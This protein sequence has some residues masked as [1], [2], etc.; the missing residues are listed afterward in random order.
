MTTFILAFTTGEK[1]KINEEEAKAIAKTNDNQSITLKRLGMVI[2]KRMVQVYPEALSDTLADRRK[3][4]TGVLYDGTRVRRHFGRWIK[5]DGFV[6]DDDSSYQ[7]VRID[8]AYYPEVGRDCVPTE[9]EWEEIKL[10]PATERR[11]FIAKLSGG[12]RVS[13]ITEPQSMKELIDK[14]NEL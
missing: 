13:E 8:P 1:F 7:P 9:H 10:L 3:Q 4:L 6:P 11:G 14:K 5:D 12:R 2:Q